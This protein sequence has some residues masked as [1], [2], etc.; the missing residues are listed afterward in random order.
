MSARDG[1]AVVG[2]GAW[3]L[4]LAAAA[5]RAGRTAFV[6][7]RRPLSEGLPAGVSR[8][9]DYR[10]IAERS[11]LVILAVPSGVARASARALGEHIDGRH[12]VV[13]GVRGLVGEAMETIG[14]VVRDET[15]ARRIGALGGP[16]LVD[17][18]LA[19]RPSVLVCGSDF[20]EV[21]A[22]VSEAFTH[23][24]L[25][26]YAIADRR[27][28]EW[29]SAL[30]GCLAIGMGYAQGVGAS[31]GLVAALLSRSVHEAARLAEAA[32]GEERTLLGLAG[33]GDLLAAIGQ[34]RR[35]EVVLGRALANG[36]KLEVAL[37]ASGQRI[38]AVELVPR[39][40]AW[41]EANGVRAPIFH[42]LAHGVLSAKPTDEIVRA[43]MTGPQEA[44]TI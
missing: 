44:G 36:A 11:R 3:G 25:R 2:G 1:V 6:L 23:E 30:V 31:P 21:C 35:P 18:L 26:L 10:E 20:P 9:N 39:V 38:E 29:A 8:V 22:A 19:G 43:L 34:E 7:S 13:H 15:P 14:D 12:L 33:Y 24:T 41:A 27:G 17:D 40:A 42:A 28:L 5:A 37:A 4:G 16:A 32:G